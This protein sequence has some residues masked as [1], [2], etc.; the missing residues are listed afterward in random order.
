[1]PTVWCVFCQTPPGKE[2]WQWPCCFLDVKPVAG[3]CGWPP[4]DTLEREQQISFHSRRALQLR[5]FP[6]EVDLQLRPI[7]AAAAA[8][9]PPRLLAPALVALVPLV[10]LA[11]DLSLSPRSMLIPLL[12]RFIFCS[13]SLTSCFVLFCFVSAPSLLT[14][15]VFLS[16]Q[17]LAV[18][19]FIAVA[20][21][22]CR[23]MTCSSVSFR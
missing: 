16:P 18:Y 20:P 15:M 14:Q 4:T 8:P 1:M 6:S 23:E 13:W 5:V 21:R 7:R 2:D 17:P 11:L 9:S 22:S 10:R 12:L 3:C 19:G